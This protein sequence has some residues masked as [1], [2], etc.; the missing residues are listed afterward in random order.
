LVVVS[1]ILLATIVV[2]IG[3]QYVGADQPVNEEPTERETRRTADDRLLSIGNA[4]SGYG[5]QYIDPANPNILNVFMLDTSDEGQLAAAKT[6]IREEFPDA[7]PPGGVNVVRGDYSIVQ[8]K[9]WYDALA[10]ALVRSRMISDGLTFIDLGEHNNRLIIAVNDEELIP[11]VKELAVK[12]GVP[13]EAV[14][15]IVR[16]PYRFLSG[17]S[18]TIRDK[19]RPNIGGVQTQ[20][21]GEGYCTQGFN[22]IRSGEEGVVVNAHCTGSFTA[23]GS[24]VFY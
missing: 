4:A 12:A 16:G 11:K 17:S 20:G 21:K 2:F 15:V 1:A 18:I 10:V 13:S 9:A 23:M 6:V 19:T 5:G 24:T 7:I 8:L 14:E 3:W 22:A